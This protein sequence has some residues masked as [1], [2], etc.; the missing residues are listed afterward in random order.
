MLCK[1]QT[2]RAAQVMRVWPLGAAL[3]EEASNYLKLRW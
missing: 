3:Q 2:V 1:Q